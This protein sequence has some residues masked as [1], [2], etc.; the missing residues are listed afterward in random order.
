MQEAEPVPPEASRPMP[1][2]RL[3]ALSP[4]APKALWVGLVV[5]ILA[6]AGGASAWAVTGASNGGYRTA[7]ATKGAVTQTLDATGTI[8]PV[9]QAQLAFHVSGQVA[10]VAVSTGQQVGQG[11]VLATLNTSSLTSSVDAAQSSISTAQQKL[12]SDENSETSDPPSTTSGASNATGAGDHATNGSSSSLNP[13]IGT[14][15]A[16]LT[17]DQHKADFD[18]AQAKSDLAQATSTCASLAQGASSPVG[19]ATSGSPNEGSSS[20]SPGTGGG[21]TGSPGG[22]NGTNGTNGTGGDTGIGGVTGGT[23]SCTSELQG[24]IADQQKVSQDQQAVAQDESALARALTSAASS[25]ASSATGHS[26]TGT[27]SSSSAGAGSGSSS[28]S[29][30]VA[31]PMQVAADQATLD[32]DDAELSEAQASLDQAQL[33]SPINGIVAS[34]GFATGESVSADSSSEEVTVVGPQS[35]EVTTTVPVTDL[36]EVAVGQKAYIVPDGRSSKLT[37]EVTQ[38]GPPPTSS[39]STDYPVTIS[40]PGVTQGLYDGASATVSIVVDQATDAVT[41]PTSALHEL[42]RIAFVSELRNGKLVEVPITLGVVGDTVSQVSSGVR[43]GDTVVLANMSEPLPTSNLTGR[44]AF[45]GVGALTGGGGGR[46]V[47]NG[48]GGGG[49]GGTKVNV[50]QV[51]G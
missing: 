37:G 51:P 40:L 48:G 50:G 21:T 11:Q 18:S 2:T 36:S 35:F 7:T 19:S 26:G 32:A 8:E 16:S 3:R 39:S 9:N 49:P 30:A 25:L 46:I 15:Q 23:S 13:V 44:A 6:I 17:S 42:G 14:E 12:T 29:S 10:S 28:A 43:A 33:V 31:N 5:S 22:T 27:G 1:E 47:F 4:R 41:V 45:A 38:V 34:V 24:V 20:N